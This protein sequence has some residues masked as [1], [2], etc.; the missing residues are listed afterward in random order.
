MVKPAPNAKSVRLHSLEILKRIEFDGAYTDLVLSQLF[1]NDDIPAK[2]RAFIS[3]LIRGTVRWKKYLDWIVGHFWQDGRKKLDKNIRLVL[4]MGLYQLAFMRVPEFAAVNESVELAKKIAGK[5]WPGIVNAILKNF[6]R[7]KSKIKLPDRQQK[8]VQYLAVKY[9]HPEWLVEHWLKRM[10][11]VQV[12]ALCK[13]NNE[14]PQLTVRYNSLNK[15]CSDFEN[16]LNENGVE[17]SKGDI[18]GFYKV[19]N[20]TYTIQLELMQKG[21][22]T[23]QDQSAGIPALLAAPKP[24]Q[25]ILDVCAAPGGK[26]VFLAELSND[27]AVIIAGD[28]NFSRIKL[29]KE[30]SQRLSLNSIKTV[31]ADA[32]CFPA[33]QADIVMV[34]APCSGLGVLA[35]KPDI[36][37]QRSLNDIYELSKLQL[38]LLEKNLQL[39]KPGGFL[40]YS[41]CT[42]EPTENEQVVEKFLKKHQNCEI[43][44][45]DRDL[46]P[47]SLVDSKNMVHTCPGKNN[48]DGSFSVKIKVKT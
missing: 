22:L 32:A 26:S 35:K 37:W 10:E 7:N 34:D 45:P 17:F 23:V 12:E 41:T 48:M 4:W 2:D 39:V 11:V 33:K 5:P 24:G 38:L 6:L 31:Q 27:Q 29:I 28:L 14:I 36:R 46:V 20:L 19:K 25:R 13:A 47:S 21:L 15:S 40:V 16:I 1:R 8:P 9:S 3:E 43:I 44:P 30:T 42:I 18:D